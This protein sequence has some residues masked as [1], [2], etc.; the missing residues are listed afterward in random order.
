MLV[1][2]VGMAAAV[3]LVPGVLNP[4]KQPIR[5]KFAEVGENNLSVYAIYERP[6]DHPT[7]YVVRKYVA[8]PGVVKIG[9]VIGTA[10]TLDD[11]RKLVPANLNKFD[12]HPVDDK[13][14]VET[15]L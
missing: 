8:K 4:E 1:L 3:A 10:P 9:E 11:A 5:A 13:A 7:G 6:R 14:I 2:V 12:R 15:W